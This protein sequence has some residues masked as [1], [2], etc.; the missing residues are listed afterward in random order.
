MARDEN[1]YIVVETILAFVPFM[2][3]VIS[4]LSLVN[5]VS[6]QARMHYALTQTANTL[7][8]YSYLLDVTGVADAL[9]ANSEIAAETAGDIDTI[10]GDISS[11]L[12][13]VSSLTA[14]NAEDVFDSVE[15]TVT[16]VKSVVSEI[17]ED[18][19]AALSAFLNFGIQEARDYILGELAAQLVGRYL[20]NGTQKGDDYLKGAKVVNTSNKKTGLAALDFYRSPIT[21]ESTTG[22]NSVLINA[23]G[24]IQLVVHYEV[25][26][27]FGALPLPFRPTLKIMQAVKTKAWLSGAGDGYEE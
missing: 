10:K 24:D 15:T 1:G 27:T 7:S 21:L 20:S 26:Y 8:V 2:L 22:K 18:P 19:K 5:I 3:L 13:G 12:E 4:I 17:Q 16:D 25:E 6:L 11:V 9:Q 14:E 23:D